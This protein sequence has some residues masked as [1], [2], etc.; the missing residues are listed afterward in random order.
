[1]RP[2]RVCLALLLALAVLA[3]RAAAQEPHG[4]ATPGPSA[5]APAQES[6]EAPS[7]E[8]DVAEIEALIA[9]IQARVNALGQAGNQRRL[10]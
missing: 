7:E 1:M 6:V 5:E 8:N 10:Q 3:G 9:N 4:E 2:V